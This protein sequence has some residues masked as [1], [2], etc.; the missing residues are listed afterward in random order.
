MICIQKVVDALW[1]VVWLLLRKLSKINSV[2]WKPTRYMYACMCNFVCSL[3]LLVQ[4]LGLNYEKD[5][6]YRS[7]SIDGMNFCYTYASKRCKE[8]GYQ[9]SLAR[10]IRCI[11]LH[12]FQHCFNFAAFARFE[13][14]HFNTKHI[15]ILLIYNHVNTQPFSM[16]VW[17][18]R[19]KQKKTYQEYII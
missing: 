7:Y 8:K 17:T 13:C 6:I 16:F 18:C 15:W 9:E 3:K 14:I 19:K 10:V 2:L 5:S 1:S 11:C 4:L 12:S